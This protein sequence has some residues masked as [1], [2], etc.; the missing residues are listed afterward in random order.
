MPS[1]GARPVA[2]VGYHHVEKLPDGTFRGSYDQGPN[3]WMTWADRNGDGRMSADE[4]IHVYIKGAER[5]RP[6]LSTLPPVDW[7]ELERWITDAP[8]F[9]RETG[10]YFIDRPLTHIPEVVNGCAA[11]LQMIARVDLTKLS[12]ADTGTRVT[13]ATVMWSAR[14]APAARSCTWRRSRSC[15][16]HGW[17]EKPCSTRTS[18]GARAPGNKSDHH[19]DGRVS[20]T[21]TGV[22][23]RQEPPAGRAR[24]IWN[25][26]IGF[27]GALH[28]CE[29]GVGQPARSG[30]APLE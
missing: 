16:A 26:G 21:V 9:A 11:R 22:A 23:I 29:L 7:T 13:L 25:Q 10:D 14:A 3:Q 5:L 15:P 24:V 19:N 4:I 8:Q 12:A 17:R 6:D 2:L 28:Q 27:Y 20:A 18:A 30:A 1:P